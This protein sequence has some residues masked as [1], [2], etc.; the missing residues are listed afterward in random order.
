M[1]LTVLFLKNWKTNKKQEYYDLRLFPL[2]VKYDFFNILNE[3]FCFW[4][5]TSINVVKELS[6]I[7]FM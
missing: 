1:L 3:I 7:Y 5:C 4:T 2:L 6:F